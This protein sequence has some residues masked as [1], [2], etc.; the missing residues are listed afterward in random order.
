MHL[1]VSP[2]VMYE[3]GRHCN[4]IGRR[5]PLRTMLARMLGQAFTADVVALSTTVRTAL[6]QAIITAAGA[7]SRFLLYNGTR[8]A[9]GG[10]PAGTLL[11]TLI[12]GA[13]L[14]V[15]TAGVIDIDESGMTQTAASHVNGTPTWLRLTTSGGTFVADFSIPGDASFSANVVN[16]TNITF[17]ASTITMPNA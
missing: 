2:A 11:A 16:G 4:S 6:A 10:T 13:V 17:N 3:F 14:G 7:N 15:A 1:A 8:P 12:M 5:Q 9:S